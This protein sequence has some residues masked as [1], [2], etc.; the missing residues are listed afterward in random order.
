M[1]AHEAYLQQKEADRK[2]ARRR[3][4]P[5]VAKEG[6]VCEITIDAVERLAEHHSDAVAL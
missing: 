2:R 1:K 6:E 5:S 4:R 3:N